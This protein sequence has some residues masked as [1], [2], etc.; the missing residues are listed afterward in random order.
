MHLLFLHLNSSGPHVP[1]EHTCILWDILYATLSR[2]EYSKYLVAC[3]AYTKCVATLWH[4]RIYCVAYTKCV[5]TLWHD[6][7]YC[8]A[9]TKCV[10]TL[11]H[12]RIYCVA[13]TKC[14]ATL[15]HGRIYLFVHESRALVTCSSPLVSHTCTHCG[16]IFLFWS[17]L[18]NERNLIFAEGEGWWARY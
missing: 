13:Y 18:Q 1:P 14:V 7:I 16:P 8:V 2:L 4:G 12:D 11:W 6:R 5:A 9:Y 15:W 10:A 3:V 17:E